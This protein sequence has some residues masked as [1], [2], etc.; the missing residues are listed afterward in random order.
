M[1]Q[2]AS[3]ALHDLLLV[4]QGRALIRGWKL[5]SFFEGQPNAQNKT[6]IRYETPLIGLFLK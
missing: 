6:I 3:G 1:A 2:L 4:P 5:I